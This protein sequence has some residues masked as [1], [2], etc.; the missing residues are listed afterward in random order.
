MPSNGNSFWVAVIAGALALVFAGCGPFRQQADAQFGDQNFKSAIAL[1]ELHK[2]RFGNY[3]DSL[4]DLRFTGL[5]DQNY[6]SAV[7]Y[8]KL[9]DGYELN[10]TRGWIGEPDLRYPAEFWR[11]IGIRK[12]NVKRTVQ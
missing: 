5:W 11:G 2:V 10:V 1:I 9:D 8:K 4:A 12:T 6:I 3:P 7:E